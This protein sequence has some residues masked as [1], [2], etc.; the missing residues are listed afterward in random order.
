M[1]IS[2]ITKLKGSTNNNL[3]PKIGE[4]KVELPSVDSPSV[5]NRGFTVD[6]A[7]AETIRLVNANFTSSSLGD[8]LGTSL[9]L[10]STKTNSAYISN[11]DATFFIPN[12]YNI[13]SF[14]AGNKNKTS[15]HSPISFDLSE[16]A[17]SKALN[18]VNLSNTDVYGDIAAFDG[19]ANLV[20]LSLDNCPSVS[21]DL[22]NVKGLSSF[23]GIY[24]LNDD[25][26]VC[27]MS[28]VASY[29]ALEEIS[30]SNKVYGDLSLLPANVVDVKCNVA[31][32]W[33]GTRSSSSKIFTCENLILGSDIDNF[34]INMA[35]CQKGKTG[36]IGLTGTRTSASDEAISTIKNYGYIIWVNGVKQ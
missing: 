24:L 25:N 12:K 5:Q 1:G 11:A 3:L 7:T 29:T 18:I 22:K 20:Y 33:K 27:N 36:N 32:S 15:V 26:V 4:M 28:D 17:Y 31:V 14:S 6:I 8:N 10:D 16:L 9:P 34:L 35:N 2:L 23:K 21:G 30:L 13:T 19:K